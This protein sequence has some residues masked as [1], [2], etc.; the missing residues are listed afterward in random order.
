MAVEE[1]AKRRTL[2]RYVHAV[3]A[4]ANWHGE[5]PSDK[6]MLQL[7]DSSVSDEEVHAIAA[8]LK[9][10]QT[11]TELNLRTNKVRRHGGMDAAGL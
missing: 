3:K 9:G 8:L 11:I 5:P 4:V 10:N 1:E 2:L 7:P 6:G